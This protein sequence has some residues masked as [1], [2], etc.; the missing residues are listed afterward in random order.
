MQFQTTR[1]GFLL[2]FALIGLNLNLM[3][4]ETD[5]KIKVEVLAK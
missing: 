1:S 5:E 2:A 4:H 3:G